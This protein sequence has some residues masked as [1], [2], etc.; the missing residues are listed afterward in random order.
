MKISTSAPGEHLKETL[1]DL[2]GIRV[3]VVEKP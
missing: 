1:E 2:V 3:E